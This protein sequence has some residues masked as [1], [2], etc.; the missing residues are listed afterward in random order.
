MGLWTYDSTAVLMEH[1][2]SYRNHTGNDRDGSGF[3]LDSNVSDS[4]IQYNLSF[5]NDGPGY[6]TFQHDRNGLHR[7]NTIR[8]NISADD[9]RKLPTTARSACTASTPGS[10][11]SS[12]TRS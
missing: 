7:D 10:C 3:G 9:G 8:Y 1:N 5:H 11:R 2:L 4:T 6:Y 12:R